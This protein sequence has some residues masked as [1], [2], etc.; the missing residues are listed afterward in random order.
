MPAKPI[1]PRAMTP[2]DRQQ[3]RR[4]RLKAKHEQAIA[5]RLAQPL[6]YSPE[7]NAMRTHIG[8]LARYLTT[9]PDSSFLALLLATID[10]PVL[11][12]PMCRR[13]LAGS[14]RRGVSLLRPDPT[15]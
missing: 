9:L 4:D 6:P 10:G 7:L 5:A 12:Y 2:A 8:K 1:G 11:P 14:V 15:G 13:R 3:R